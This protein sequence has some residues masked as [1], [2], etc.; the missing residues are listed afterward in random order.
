[1]SRHPHLGAALL[2]CSLLLT[3]AGAPAS[4]AAPAPE[5]EIGFLVA[6]VGTPSLRFPAEP[7]QTVT[8]RIRIVN[9]AAKGRT[10]RLTTADLV[11]ADTGGAS[12]PS[13]PP[14]STGTWL[15]LGRE[16]V[17]LEG[18]EK[19]TV[20]FRVAVPASAGPGQHFAGIV[21]VDAA[22]AAT[23][24][25]PSTKGEGVEV[26]HLARLALPVRLTV[27]GARFTQL[28]V[29][30]MH[31]SVDASGSS[32]RVG[33]RNAGNEI[34]RET[35]MDL[36]IS[37]DGKELL[38]A[39]NEI[40]DFITGTEISYP[41]AWRGALQPGA[42]EVTGTIRPLGGSPITIDQTVEFTPELAETLE[43]K[44]GTP[45]APAD[46]Q[47]L[48]I[49]ALLAAV[50]AAGGAVTTAYLRLRRRINAA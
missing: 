33:L 17:V 18:H 8:G 41:V 19:E 32:L 25:R 50:L 10:I 3:L 47:P 36:H 24:R 20:G 28:A 16:R 11:T 27:P 37:R 13:E 43:Q 6:P 5:R 15:E 34:V 22:E 9:L 1:M 46:G 23:A 31:F 38:A 44:T 21:A 29:T 2:G 30:D 35:D 45:A 14:T 12:F 42:Y 26:R 7:G 40:R 4:S 48:W 49:W 39:R